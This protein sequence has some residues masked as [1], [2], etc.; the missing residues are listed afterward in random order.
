[1]SER[2]IKNSYK[3]KLAYEPIADELRVPGI[4]TTT[5][6]NSV[7]IGAVTID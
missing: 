6:S 4:S 2:S 5:V 1:L 7:S 3:A